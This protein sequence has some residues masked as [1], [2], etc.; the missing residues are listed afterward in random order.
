MMSSRRIV[1]FSTDDVVAATVCWQL[2]DKAP[3]VF[4][5][6][7]GRPAAAAVVVIRRSVGERKV[8]SSSLTSR[9]AIRQTHH[10]DSGHHLH[11]EGLV[12]GHRQVHLQRALHS[13]RRGYKGRRGLGCPEPLCCF[14]YFSFNWRSKGDGREAQRLT[15]VTK[16]G[17]YARRKAISIERGERED[18]RRSWL[19]GEKIGG[20][21]GG[22]I[23]GD[24]GE[25]RKLRR[26][27][28]WL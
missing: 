1:P 12:F 3:R 2:G 10:R 17:V 23:L 7:Q 4:S 11:F 28:R 21:G 8:P 9:I 26:L 24:D 13:H 6:S 5:Q 14:F 25:R 18:G 27:L 22:W 16:S 19:S 15:C 20:M